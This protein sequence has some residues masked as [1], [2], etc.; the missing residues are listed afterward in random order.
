ME[1]NYSPLLNNLDGISLLISLKNFS[2]KN[3]RFHK[4]VSIDNG[5]KDC[6]D[7]R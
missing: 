6:V 7:P 1:C 2:G 5:C 4:M 3:T